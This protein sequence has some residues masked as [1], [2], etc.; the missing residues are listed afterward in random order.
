MRRR[1]F[2]ASLGIAGILPA[3]AWAQPAKGVPVI[4]VLISGYPDV[5]VNAL[6]ENLRTLG[7]AEGSGLRIEVRH[8]A[9]GN[10]ERLAA[11]AQE[12]VRM[13]VDV[14]IAVQTPAAQAAQRASREVPIVISAGDP[15]ATGLVASLARPGGNITGYS[16]T[17]ADLGGKLLQLIREL[18]PATKRVGVLANAE[19]PFTKTFLAQLH[20]PARTLGMEIQDYVVRRVEDYGGAFAK[21]S[22]R[23]VD[24]VLVQPSLARKEAVALAQQYRL[25]AVSPSG[26]FTGEGGLMSYSGSAEENFRVLSVYVDRILKGAKPADLPIQ[27]PTRFDLRLNLKTARA[28]GIEVPPLLL[29]RADKVIE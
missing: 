19:D 1:N 7:Y 21:M 15:V 23:Y 10:A 12:L 25:P 3:I 27:Q 29:A 16:A 5:I 8:V 18:L 24:V 14:L 2:A 11:L 26:L 20:A 13:K 22:K 6:R 28:L 9:G 17:V 4:G